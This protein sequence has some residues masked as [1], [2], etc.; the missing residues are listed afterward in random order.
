MRRI[1]KND[2]SQKMSRAVTYSGKFEKIVFS[3]QLGVGDGRSE[4][5]PIAKSPFF[6]K[7]DMDC[8]LLPR[9]SRCPDDV[10]WQTTKK[11]QGLLNHV[12]NLNFAFLLAHPRRSPHY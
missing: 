6:A 9:S 12:P 7:K 5:P 2:A 10:A 1:L 4:L 11:A 3:I 8:G